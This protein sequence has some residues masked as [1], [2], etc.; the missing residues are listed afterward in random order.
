M[1]TYQ[2]VFTTEARYDLDAIYNYIAF[3]VENPFGAV[4][5][6]DAILNKCLKLVI[7]PKA[8]AIR[9]VVNGE[10]IRFT[11]AGKYTIAYCINDKNATVYVK[12]IFYSR[13]NIRLG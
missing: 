10:S 8:S 13:R 1:K 9:Y 5:V 3:D 4:K 7:V 2:V 6:I 11:R 12:T